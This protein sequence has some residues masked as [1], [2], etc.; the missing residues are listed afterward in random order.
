M[1]PEFPRRKSLRLPG[2]DYGSE[3]AYFV[4]V[5]TKDH[6][7]WFRD[8]NIAEILEETWERLPDRIPRIR[9]DAFV[10]MP[11]HI[12][13]VL[14]MGDN[15]STNPTVSL[16]EVVRHLKAVVA[17]RVRV[18]GNPDFA[19]QRNYYEHVVRDEHDLLRIREY[20][21]LNPEGPW[22]CL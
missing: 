18:A 4:T 2:Y 12:H 8:K 9:R 21:R 1:T 6:V 11:D 7:P 22:G 15:T 3:G 5:C 20:I 19:W 17:R 13:F 16:G 10:V 14:W